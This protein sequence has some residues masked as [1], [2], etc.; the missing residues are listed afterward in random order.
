MA[1]AT[2]WNH[3]TFFCPATRPLVA[4]G[5]GL[6]GLRLEG[7]PGLLASTRR[8]SS[9]AVSEPE[10]DCVLP[11]PKPIK[12]Q[13]KWRKLYLPAI[14]LVVLYILTITRLLW[15]Y[16]LADRLW[17]SS[18]ALSD[19]PHV[20]IT[21]YGEAAAAAP[22]FTKACT[23]GV[24][25][26][27]GD[28]V[29]QLITLKSRG[30]RMDAWRVLRNG[31]AGFVL[32]GPILHYWIVLLEGPVAA[33][34]SSWGPI[35]AWCLKIA[36]DQTIFAAF[37]NMAYAVFVGLLEGMWPRQTIQRAKTKLLPMMVSSWRFWPFVHM[38]TYSPLIP[39]DFKLLWN[40]IMEII[41]VA[42]LSLINNEKPVA[43][44]GTEGTPGTPGV[45][46]AD[47]NCVPV[48]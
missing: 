25:Y 8:A 30:G 11:D 10:P 45:L 31:L 36:L 26:V 24:S 17:Y 20:L 6:V 32:H 1:A 9:E 15:M 19:L 37:L 4:R 35:K 18:A 41:W 14:M 27:I 43:P 47:G 34:T 28:I 21:R 40:D 44:E 7:H 13:R 12:V 22:V 16:G 2:K 42:I 29:A 33:A 48:T 39:L 38:M 46:D 5:P 23:S 3:L